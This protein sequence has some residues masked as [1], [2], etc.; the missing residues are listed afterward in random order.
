MI[1]ITFVESAYN[2]TDRGSVRHV[3]VLIVDKSCVRDYY[4]FA[5]REQEDMPNK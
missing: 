2:N 5:N 1:L 4:M 3:L